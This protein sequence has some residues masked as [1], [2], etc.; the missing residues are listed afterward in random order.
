M[1]SG[2]LP[3]MDLM[4]VRKQALLSY[5]HRRWNTRAGV[6][7]HITVRDPGDPSHFWY[8]CFHA[9]V[10]RMPFI[11]F[12]VN[13]FGVPF[14]LMTVS[15]LL[16]IDHK[17]EIIGGGKRMGLHLFNPLKTSSYRSISEPSDIQSS[18]LLHPCCHPCCQTGC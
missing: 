15:D 9:Q 7:G 18:R 4:K 8:V 10:R 13:P 6:A 11:I 1:H 12:R 5:I 17:G 2:Y 14:A 16:L 3:S